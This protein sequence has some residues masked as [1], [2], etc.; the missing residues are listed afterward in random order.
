MKKNFQP[1]I[2]TIGVSIDQHP[3]LKRRNIWCLCVYDCANFCPIIIAS[4]FCMCLFACMCLNN[5][6]I[7]PK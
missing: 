5:V 6:F 1:L 3:L 4:D 7:G 2:N